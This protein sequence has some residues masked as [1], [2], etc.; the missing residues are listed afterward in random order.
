MIGAVAGDDAVVMAPGSYHRDIAMSQER[1]VLSRRRP[2][3]EI[4]PRIGRSGQSAGLARPRR[5]RCLTAAEWPSRANLRDEPAFATG[6]AVA[7]ARQGRFR[8]TSRRRFRSSLSVVGKHPD[9]VTIENEA[10][11]TAPRRRVSCGAECSGVSCRRASPSLT[12]GGRAG[13]L[14]NALGLGTSEREHDNVALEP[15]GPL[16]PKEYCDDN[17]PS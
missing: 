14:L 6:N 9:A 2:A 15:S 7:I 8:G 3:R 4:A 1:V 10:Q 5:F 16:G 13:G 11:A 12:R 17:L